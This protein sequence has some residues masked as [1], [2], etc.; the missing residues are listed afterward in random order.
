MY[1]CDYCGARFDLP[2]FERRDEY[3][4]E[5]DAFEPVCVGLCPA[6]GCDEYEEEE[7]KNDE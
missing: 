3:H 5:V 7:E 4:P 6:C 1:V 2:F